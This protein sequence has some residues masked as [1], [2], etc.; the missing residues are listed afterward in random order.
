[1]LW[2]G[3]TLPDSAKCISEGAPTSG[4]SGG[5]PPDTSNVLIVW[6][7]FEDSMSC[8]RYTYGDGTLLPSWFRRME[9]EFEEY[10]DWQ[11]YGKHYVDAKTAQGVGD[12]SLKAWNLGKTSCY[13]RAAAS[14]PSI[15]GS[16]CP[17]S[18][19][20]TRSAG[21]IN[22]RVVD[23]IADS[24]GASTFTGIDCVCF[25]HL[26]PAFTDERIAGW[27]G[28]AYGRGYSCPSCAYNG[29]AT[30]QRPVKGDRVGD[31]LPGG[32]EGST[33]YMLAHEFGHFLGLNHT[34]GTGDDELE[35]IVDMGRYSPMRLGVEQDVDYV[36]D[37][38]LPYHPWQIT[39]HAAPSGHGPI[40]WIDSTRFEFVGVNTLDIALPN[41]RSSGGNIV[42]V[43]TKVDS[44]L[45]EFWVIHHQNHEF[46]AIYDR[47]GLAIWHMRDP[48]NL[49][50]FPR[51]DMDLELPTGKRTAPPCPGTVSNAAAGW[52][53]L[54]CDVNNGHKSDFFGADDVFG[55]LTNP[56]SRD[57]STPAY[58]GN[59]TVKTN[60]KVGDIRLQQFVSKPNYL[61]DVTYESLT[62]SPYLYMWN[63][64][65]F[66]R[67]GNV[68]PV[69]SEIDFDTSRLD[70]VF[71]GC[72]T[73]IEGRYLFKIREDGHTR[74]VVDRADVVVIDHEPELSLAVDHSGA[75]FGYRT[76]RHIWD[77]TL[78]ESAGG[79]ITRLGNP[80]HGETGA[81]LVVE[82]A[83]ADAGD[84]LVITHKGLAGDDV[85]TSPALT[86]ERETGE[87]EWVGVGALPRRSWFTKECI[88]L[89]R[90]GHDGGRLLLRLR[91]LDYHSVDRVAV[92]RPVDPGSFV[93]QSL[94]PDTL[95]VAYKVLDPAVLSGADGVTA[96]VEH[97]EKLTFGAAVPA[98]VEGWVQSVAVVLEGYYGEVAGSRA[99]DQ[100]PGS[101]IAFATG[102]RPNPFNPSTA[103]EFGL[104]RGGR[105]ELALYS[106]D[107]RLVRQLV[108][109]P[110]P[111]GEHSVVWDGRSDSGLPQKSGI[112]FY[113]LRVGGASRSGKLVLTK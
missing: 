53:S 14:D 102:G 52:D 72:Q 45:S 105:V 70:A 107:G 73:P 34:P 12:D 111:A 65:N 35:D 98:A 24:L 67:L 51:T 6:V 87:G 106:V 25:I 108:D 82:W 38:F 97:A 91:W 41:I 113:S 33:K 61:I 29:E 68:L 31:P 110:L 86:L 103:I 47:D 16:L 96:I 22:P 59:Q 79:D 3:G 80:V 89:N 32:D 10:Y 64:R 74:T 88:P 7:G 19:S 83:T 92:V 54:E 95:E 48:E 23:M 18:Y 77:A 9:T 100:E 76:E 30:T 69:R 57:Y 66:P 78:P 27:G 84:A 5:S 46:D 17:Y 81:V 90:I 8:N 85:P 11:S 37:S 21:C 75:V 28:G 44:F 4:Y 36:D 93:V 71:V 42:R 1:M 101:A 2:A 55:D 94:A 40:A 109:A 43:D 15:G 39:K 50:S 26:G 112:Y 63:G 49:S 99:P 13:W 58:P 20:D 56:S 62:T 60:V 104:V